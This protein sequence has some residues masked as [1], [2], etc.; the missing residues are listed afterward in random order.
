[1]STPTQAP[2]IGFRTL[3]AYFIGVRDV[4][5]HMYSRPS[6]PI[7]AQPSWIASSRWLRRTYRAAWNSAGA[8]ILAFERERESAARETPS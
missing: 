5:V 8:E 3:A 2:P 7:P 6:T 4:E 1:M